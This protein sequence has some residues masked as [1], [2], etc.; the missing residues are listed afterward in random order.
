MSLYNKSFIIFWERKQKG[1]AYESVDGLYDYIQEN[2]IVPPQAM[3]SFHI[4]QLL[5]ETSADVNEINVL[6]IRK[7][8]EIVS[9]FEEL[10]I[11]NEGSP[12]ALPPARLMGMA[13]EL[14]IGVFCTIFKGETFP[15]EIAAMVDLTKI[16][17]SAKPEN[18]HG[19]AI[20]TLVN[21]NKTI[22]VNAIISQA[23]LM[24]KVITDLAGPAS[25][26]STVATLTFGGS[27]IQLNREKRSIIIDLADVDDTKY[28]LNLRLA[29]FHGIDLTKFDKLEMRRNGVFLCSF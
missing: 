18:I 16:T 28:V 9:S 8:Y 27:R 15:E 24:K 21:L 22:P 10:N 23:S 19:T 13:D 5:I 11:S 20:S 1:F 7:F 2:I 4:N 17:I 12:F 14:T 29:D 3:E 25:G 26:F 6:G